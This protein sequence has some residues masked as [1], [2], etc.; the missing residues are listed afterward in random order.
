MATYANYIE[1]A[2]V[3]DLT[4]DRYNL[5]RPDVEAY[6]HVVARCRFHTLSILPA[7]HQV[8]RLVIIVV[9]RRSKERV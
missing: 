5:G 2:I 6:D 7:P 8:R 9:P 3:Y 4:N 1:T